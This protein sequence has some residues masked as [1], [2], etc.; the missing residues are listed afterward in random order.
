MSAIKKHKKTAAIIKEKSNENG[1][2]KISV[3]NIK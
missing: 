3:K 2:C 1:E